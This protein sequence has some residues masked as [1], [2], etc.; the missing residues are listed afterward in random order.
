MRRQISVK[1]PVPFFPPRKS[2][3]WQPSSIR[4]DGRTGMVKLIVASHICFASAPT[5]ITP[6]HEDLFICLSTIWEWSH[7]CGLMANGL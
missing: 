4:I 3:Q 7:H 6:F 1:P 2:V 5:N